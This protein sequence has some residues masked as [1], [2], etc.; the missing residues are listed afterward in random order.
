MC[1]MLL[2]LGM[3]ANDVNE[4]AFL[5]WSRGR[6]TDATTRSVCQDTGCLGAFV[7]VICKN[8]LPLIDYASHIEQKVPIRSGGTEAACK[9]LVKGL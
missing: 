4:K 8:Q 6:I 3:I 7:V 2:N 1:Q 5:T 9:A